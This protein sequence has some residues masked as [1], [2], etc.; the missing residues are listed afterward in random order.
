MG[1]VLST[2]TNGFPGTISR[3]LDNIVISMKNE[4]S[5]AIPFGAPVFQRSGR[6]GCLP[7]DAETS[8]A[9]AFLGFTVREAAKAPDVYG[10]DEADFAP[11]DPVEVLVRGSIILSFAYDVTPGSSVY[12]RKSDGA[13]VTEAGGEGSTLKLPNVTVRTVSDGDCRAEVV[14]TARNLM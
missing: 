4:S 12:I 3:S 14:I 7:F 8:A 13:F 2:F 11:G 1:K 10:A 9:A 6:N 5:G